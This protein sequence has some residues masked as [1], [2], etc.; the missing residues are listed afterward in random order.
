M[1]V[2]WFGNGISSIL[3][4]NIDINFPQLLIEPQLSA[5]DDKI[6][7]LSLIGVG[8]SRTFNYTLVISEEILTDSCF[9]I[10]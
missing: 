9:K 7:T 8:E 4:N 3:K 10:F 5:F 6:Q 1:R 2:Y